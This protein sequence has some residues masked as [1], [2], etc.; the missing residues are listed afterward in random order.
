MTNVL[1]ER[2]NLPTGSGASLEIEVNP[3]SKNVLVQA[4]GTPIKNG[5]CPLL[6]T[7]PNN[8]HDASLTQPAIVFL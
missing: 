5:G 3:I 4:L 7:T 2:Q 1:K 6:R 8:D